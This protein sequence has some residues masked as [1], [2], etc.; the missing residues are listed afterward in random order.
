MLNF[1]SKLCPTA[2]LTLLNL[3]PIQRAL[4][5]PEIGF[6][7]LS[8]MFL[9]SHSFQSFCSMRGQLYFL[10]RRRCCSVCWLLCSSSQLSSPSPLAVNKVFPTLCVRL[11]SLSHPYPWLSRPS[12]IAVSQTSPAS[13]SGKSVYRGQNE[14]SPDPVPRECRLGE[15]PRF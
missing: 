6:V 5:F 12:P 14:M 4:R 10:C 8:K 1:G 15:T 13:S 7:F 11:P 3:L 2:V 9:R